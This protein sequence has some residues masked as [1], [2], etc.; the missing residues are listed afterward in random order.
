MSVRPLPRLTLAAVL[1]HHQKQTFRNQN[2]LNAKR[3]SETINY[4]Q[5]GAV[6]QS[7]RV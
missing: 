1:L 6:P 7:D 2:L 3:I 4:L 5:P